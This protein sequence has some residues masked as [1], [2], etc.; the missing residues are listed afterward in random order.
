MGAMHDDPTAG[1]LTI[2]EFARRSQLGTKALRHYAE[3]GLLRP[4]EVDAI[5]GYRRYAE[6][7]LATAS[8]IRLLRAVDLPL[9]EVASVL[10]TFDDRPGA[11]MALV[12]GHLAERR[13]QLDRQL[14]LV[15]HLRAAIYQEVDPM[16]PVSVHHVPATRVLS[17][18]RRLTIGDADAFLA[19][20]WDRFA[21]VIGDRPS[22]LPFTVL[23]H[24]V[25]DDVSDGPMEAI[26]GLPE[27]VEVPGDLE[28]REE[29]AH[30]E[31]RTPVTR[32][33]WDYPAILAAYDAVAR[34]A[35]VTG[36]GSS[37]LACREVYRA[38]PRTVGT[39]EVIC[40]VAIPLG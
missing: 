13:A 11:A 19:E 35:A 29:P 40:E 34:S 15:P 21:A 24:G 14:A 26:V 3:L 33:A 39:G 27:G 38:D 8:M 22:D 23:L 32:D 37:P 10:E 16:F 12:E 1:L 2:G 25:V 5:T 18:E 4:V 6:A 36:R 17:I 31:A 20:A 9:A 7:Q 30:D 28:V